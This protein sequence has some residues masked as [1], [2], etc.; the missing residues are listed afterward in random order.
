MFGAREMSKWQPKTYLVCRLGTEGK[1]EL[2]K[3]AGAESLLSAGEMLFE[4]CDNRRI[5]GID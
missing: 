2:H 3:N 1:L 4:V 5:D